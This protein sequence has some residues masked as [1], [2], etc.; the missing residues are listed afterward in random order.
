MAAGAPVSSA[1]HVGLAVAYSTVA[2][3]AHQVEGYGRDSEE[4]ISS[5]GRWNGRTIMTLGD[6]WTELEEPIAALRKQWFGDYNT[7]MT[8]F[9]QTLTDTDMRSNTILLKS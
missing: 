9:Q 8:A 6:H 4:Q 2:Q 7:E 3:Q 5:P 1:H